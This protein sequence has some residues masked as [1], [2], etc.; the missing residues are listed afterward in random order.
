MHL[1][2][3]SKFLLIEKV[4]WKLAFVPNLSLPARSVIPRWNSPHWIM[5]MACERELALLALV[6]AAFRLPMNMSMISFVVFFVIS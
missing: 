3:T 6:S 2:R 4:Y 5:K 1:P